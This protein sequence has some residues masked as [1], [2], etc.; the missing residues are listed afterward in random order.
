MV[1]TTGY[2]PI[3]TSK[4]ELQVIFC[5][6][7]PSLL[8]S[9]IGQHFLGINPS[10]HLAGREEKYASTIQFQ[11][12]DKLSDA[13]A[14]GSLSRGVA[15]LKLL[16][17]AGVRG[18]ALTD[19]A[20]KARIP[21]PT[22][23]RVLQ[24]L[25]SERL[26]DRHPELRR[27]RLGPLAFELG[28]ASATFYDIRDLCDAAMANLAGASEDTTYLV[29]R[30]GFEAVCMHRREGSFPIRTL[31]LDVG[32]RRPLGV[33][34]GGLALLSAMDDVERSAIIERVTPMLAG[35]EGLDAAVLQEACLQTRKRGYS[36][37][38]STINLGV[39]AVGQVFYSSVGQPMG[40]LSV[41]A[42]SQ[43]MTAQR[44]EATVK[45][46]DVACK[47]LGRRLRERQMVD[48]SIQY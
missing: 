15:L 5:T 8:C 29:V 23:H 19:I 10:F 24:Q 25:V 9:L 1:K 14:P 16:A 12:M 42:L 30:S 31:I 2:Q 26:V 46:L 38:K 28:L 22:V 18:M 39:T 35:Y 3:S 4:K 47:D 27:Y 32:S 6:T 11:Y 44:I 34:A 17:T 37:I 33:G 20:V 40:A 7:M 43:R 48:W 41:A 45:N 13:G 21:H 36:L